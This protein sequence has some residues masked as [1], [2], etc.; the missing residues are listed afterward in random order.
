MAWLEPTAPAGTVLVRA[1]APDD[2]TAICNVLINSD[3]FGSS[4]VE[5]VDAMF[6]ET[7]ER[8]Q[9]DGYRWLVAEDAGAVIGFACYGPESLTQDTWDL[10][11]ICVASSARRRGAGRALL[12]AALHDALAHHARLMVIYTS[13]TPPYAPARRLYAALGFRHVATV[14]DYYRDG[15]DLNIYWKRLR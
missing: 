1:A 13:S 8:P 11:W 14:P 12:Q 6:V 7:W 4:D 9:P 15:D 2:R 5:C 3:L 10:F